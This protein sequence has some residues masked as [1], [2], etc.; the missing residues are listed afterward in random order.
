MRISETETSSLEKKEMTTPK[1]PGNPD[2][3]VTMSQDKKENKSLGNDNTS[4]EIGAGD[5][6]PAQILT[7][8]ADR[9][10]SKLKDMSP[11]LLL[12]SSQLNDY[13][14]MILSSESSIESKS[15]LIHA[16]Y[17]AYNKSNRIRRQKN[18]FPNDVMKGSGRSS[19]KKQK[20]NR[21]SSKT[22]NSNVRNVR[23]HEST[24]DSEGDEIQPNQRSNKQV[25]HRY[26][27]KNDNNGS[28]DNSSNVDENL[29]GTE[30]SEEIMGEQL[31]DEQNLSTNEASENSQHSNSSGSASNNSDD[32]ESNHNDTNSNQD[33]SSDNETTST[34]MPG[35]LKKKPR[36]CISAYFEILKTLRKCGDPLEQQHRV[37][38]KKNAQR[39]AACF[40]QS[41]PV[42]YNNYNIN[43]CGNCIV[44]NKRNNSSKKLSI[45][46]NRYLSSISLPKDKLFAF[47]SNHEHNEVSFSTMEK[48]AIR[49]LSGFMNLNIKNVPFK[50]VQDICK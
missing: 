42:L 20:D 2:Q 36:S 50:K 4:K 29:T 11:P 5:L 45:A 22:S 39:L 46:I 7:S 47:V 31:S 15:N 41:L 16:A 37:K 30:E 27:S 13:V 3:N 25:T 38:M 32:N 26:V 33:Q 44:M 1:Q 28:D 12:T 21:P 10:K 23:S 40:K 19:R 34:S 17:D 49:V 6:L 48:K 24:S 9:L 8:P 43:I 35:T 14:K 18:K